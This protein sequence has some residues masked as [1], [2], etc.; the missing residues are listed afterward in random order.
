MVV[1][2]IWATVV[3]LVWA[4]TRGLGLRRVSIEKLLLLLILLVAAEE[5]KGREKRG[6]QVARRR[7]SEDLVSLLHI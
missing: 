2:V 7:K 4:E 1:K 5:L 3:M 6:R